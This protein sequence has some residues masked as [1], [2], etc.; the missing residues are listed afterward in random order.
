[1]HNRSDC[2]DQSQPMLLP[3]K[4]KCQKT[5]ETRFIVKPLE[6]NMN[7]LFD[8]SDAELSRLGAARMIA[9]TFPGYPCR[10]SLVDAQIG[11]EMILLPFEHHATTSPYRSSGP[12]FI[13]KGAVSARLGENEI[14][15]MLLHRLLS[16]RAYD[17]QGMMLAAHTLPGEQLAAEIQSLFALPDVAYLQVHNAGPGCY[18][19]QIE[20]V[21]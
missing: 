5:M 13:R 18:N 11:E 8:L 14:P 3:F 1:M 2:H 9:D 6:Q 20:R 16:V 7:Y 15:E 10:V 4:R 17:Q 12:L 19:C 21:G